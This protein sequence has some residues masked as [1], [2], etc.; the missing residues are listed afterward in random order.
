[1]PESADLEPVRIAGEHA[2]IAISELVL[3]RDIYYTLDPSEPDYV[4]LGEAARYDSSALFE[5]LADPERFAM[6]SHRAPASSGSRGPL[7]DAGRQQPLEQRWQG[8]GS[9]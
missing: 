3:K 2:E 7:P 4:N 9:G 8:L 1:M 5:L 6:L